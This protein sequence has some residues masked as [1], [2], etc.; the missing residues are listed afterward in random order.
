MTHDYIQSNFAF[1]VAITFLLLFIFSYR[2]FN[3]KISH[4]FMLAVGFTMLL[5]VVENLSV[6]SSELP[7]PT[8]I[9]RFTSAMGYSIR[10]L[11]I[12]MIILIVHRGKIKNKILL[13][14]PAVI[15]I[16][17]S[18][19][20]LFSGIAFSFTPDNEFQRGPLGF[21]AHITALVYLIVLLV[22][23]VQFFKEKSYYEGV[24]IGIIEASN[25]VATLL[26]SVWNYKGLLRTS[27]VLSLAFYYIFFQTQSTK[28]DSLTGALKRRYLYIDAERLKGR[29]QAVIS[30]DLNNLK[31]IN[32]T[33]G[34]AAG[35]EAILTFASC[36]NKTMFSGCTLYRTGGDEFMILCRKCTETQVI[37]F[38]RQLKA[39]MAQTPYSCAVGVAFFD[40]DNNFETICN[41][42]DTA[43]YEDKIKMKKELG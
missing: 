16:G 22:S 9:R 31:K 15:N 42:A 43:M 17:I 3:K 37:D 5:F 2:T 20:G 18:F 33:L 36:V 40:S 12:V 4:L 27:I 6:W 29:L 34:H 38:V 11:I 28:R 8:F 26:E 23:T 14:V 21:T 24:L 10:P 39:K 35:D 30:L 41:K 7:H 13:F 32:D 19:T 1:V 25:A